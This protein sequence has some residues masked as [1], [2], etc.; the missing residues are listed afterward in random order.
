MAYDLE[1]EKREAIA[2]GH[3]ALNS[4]RAAQSDLNQCH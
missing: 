3:R 2:A 1:K 4:L